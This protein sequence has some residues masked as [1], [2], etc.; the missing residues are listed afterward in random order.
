MKTLFDT[1]AEFVSGDWGSD[2]ESAETPSSAFCIRAADV[3]PIETHNYTTIPERHLAMRS[4]KLHRLK[5]GD[6]VIEK[7]GGSPTQSTGRVVYVSQS[8]LAARPNLVCSNFCAAIRLKNEWDPYFVYLYWRQVYNTGV[9]FNYEGKTSGLKNL[10]L[11]AAMKSIQIPEIDLPTQLRIAGVLGSLD[12]KIELN[13]KKIAELEALAKTIYDYWFVQYDF[14]DANGKPYKSSGGKMVWNDQLKREVP[15]KWA[16]GRIGDHITS[17]RGISYS[18]KNI[19]SGKGVPM[20]NLNSFNVDSSYKV[21]G[22]KTYEGDIP[23]SKQLSPFDLVMCNTQQTDLDPL[24]DIIGKSFLV[25]DI[26]DS[27]IVSSH[28]VTTIHVDN[29]DL[30][31][32]LNALFHTREFHAYISGYASGT[33][34]RGLDFFGVENCY[35]ALPHKSL[36]AKFASIAFSCEKEK[37][38]IIKD[39]QTLLATRDYLLPLLMNGQAR[40]AG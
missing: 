31:V 18:T 2:T 17:N 14:P 21:K 35:F 38:I 27:P 36:L 5:A 15:E 24:K 11:E 29:D 1:V 16:V 26:F 40:V 20:I 8:L 34:I 9:F 30:K 39:Q 6:I 7:S 3:A 19:S 32:Y 13:R 28:H 10:Q 23:L 22:L 4:F 25:P 12:E 37:S 33:S